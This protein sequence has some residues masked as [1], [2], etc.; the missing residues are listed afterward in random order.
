MALTLGN[1]LEFS[2]AREFSYNY[3]HS[4]NECISHISPQS[5]QNIKNENGA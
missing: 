4:H 3:S 1:P 5:N 2:N